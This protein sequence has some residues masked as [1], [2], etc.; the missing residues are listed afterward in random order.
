MSRTSCRPFGS[1]L[2]ADAAQHAGEERV[3]EQL[4]GRLGDDHRHRVAA[5]RHEA[6]CGPVRRVAELPDGGL[7]GGARRLA[8]APVAVDDAG[9]GGARHFRDAGDLLQGGRPGPACRHQ[10]ESAL[11]ITSRLYTASSRERSHAS[12]PSRAGLA[13]RCGGGWTCRVGITDALRDATG[14]QVPTQYIR[15]AG[16]FEADV[17]GGRQGIR[18]R[19]LG[20][21][22]AWRVFSVSDSL[23]ARLASPGRV[24]SPDRARRH[25][26]GRGARG[27]AGHR[28]RRAPLRGLRSRTG[29][30]RGRARLLADAARTGAPDRDG[31]RSGATIPSRIV[32]PSFSVAVLPCPM[33]WRSM[34]AVS[35]ASTRRSPIP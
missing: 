35:P 19:H 28:R 8:D 25:R 23:S 2:G 22:G 16:A 4:G 17:L 13:V 27:A 10:R 31:P 15:L 32:S 6:S 14:Y 34:P 12:R 33:T 29:R 1:E 3:A 5:P 9:G 21:P 18:N 20:R 11:T 7:D 24:R 30:V 26:R